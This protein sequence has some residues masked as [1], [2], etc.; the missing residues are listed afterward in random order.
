MRAE[1]VASERDTRNL[2]Q[3]ISKRPSLET[4]GV[5]DEVLLVVLLQ[6]GLRQVGAIASYTR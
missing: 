2:Q 5:L 6:R 3:E 4:D 1:D